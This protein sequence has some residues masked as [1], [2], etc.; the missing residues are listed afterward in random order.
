[1]T[2]PE[3]L[4]KLIDGHI[5]GM[6]NTLELTIDTDKSDRAY[7]QGMKAIRWLVYNF[8]NAPKVEESKNDQQDFEL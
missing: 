7:Y 8:F 4:I 5:D 1:M 3:E 2:E 6:I